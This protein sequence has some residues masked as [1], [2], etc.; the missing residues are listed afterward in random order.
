MRSPFRFLPELNWILSVFVN[1]MSI[2]GIFYFF[3]CGIINL[4]AKLHFCIIFKLKEG[5]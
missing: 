2:A 3:I 4:P 1:I 5:L